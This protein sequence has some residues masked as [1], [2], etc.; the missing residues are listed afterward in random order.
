MPKGDVKVLYGGKDVFSGICPAPYLFFEKEYIEYG[1]SWGSKYAFSIEG[2]I[3]GKLGP[4]AFYD[5][6]NKK[7]QLISGFLQDNQPISITE[8][9]VKIFDSDICL[10]DNISFEESKYYAL[11]PFSISASCYDSGS[12]SQNYGVLNPVDSWDFS[13]EKDGTVSLTHTV[14]AAGFNTSGVA[15]VNNAKKWVSSRTGISNKI[16]SLKIKNISGSCYVLDSVSEKIDRFNG[17]YS[18]DEK[19]KADLFSGMCGPGILRYSIDVSKNSEDGLTEVVVDGSVI[20]KNNI[21][22][23]NI[24]ALRNRVLNFDFFSDALASAD[25]STGSKAL[26]S[27][28]FSR[29][30]SEN[31]NSSEVSFSFSYDDNP[32]P[33]GMAKCV[34]KVTLS[35]DLIKNIIDIK[36]DAKILCDRGDISLRWDAVNDYYKKIF[37]GYSLASTAYALGGYSKGFPTIPV[38]ESINFDKFNAS[39]SYAASW[40]D[41]YLPCS[42]T[43]VSI[44]ETVSINP[45]IYI[46]TAQPSLQQN[47]V[48]NVQNIGC[49]NRTSVSIAIDATARPDKTLAQLESC[50]FAELDRLKNIYVNGSNVFLD[51]KVETTDKNYKKISLNYTYSF[52]GGIIAF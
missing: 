20:G 19:Y 23:S 27:T 7:N 42:E 31:E 18:V 39:I 51:E 25:K 29:R 38:S 5:L 15:A 21:G 11:L 30:I 26:N 52:D 3:T 8:D 34:H 49:A 44:S 48:Y 2:Q 43:L 32:I 22:L 50:V 16:E 47:G 40:S 14:S 33:P 4:A 1:S 36:L 13:E 37:N 10:I 9:G 24:S 6:E 41:R 35:E 17:A 46:Y 12:F 45:S 28:P